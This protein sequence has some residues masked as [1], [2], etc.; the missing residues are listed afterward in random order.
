MLTRDHVHFQSNRFTFDV[1]DYD[2]GKLT[3]RC[4]AFASQTRSDLIQLTAQLE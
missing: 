3:A 2:T 1:Y 4:S